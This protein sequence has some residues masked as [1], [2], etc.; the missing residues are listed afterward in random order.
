MSEERKVSPLSTSASG[1]LFAED[2][3]ERRE[4]NDTLSASPK[5]RIQSEMNAMGK[6]KENEQYQASDF[7]SKVCW[8]FSYLYVFSLTFPP[9]KFFLV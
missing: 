4:T 5:K 7:L 1:A 3:G 8:F 2:I 9:F 6:L